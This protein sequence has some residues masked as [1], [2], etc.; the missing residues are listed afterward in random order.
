MISVTMNDVLNIEKV[1][2]KLV[3]QSLTGKKAFAMARLAREVEKEVATFENIRME[4]IRKYANKDE[5]GEA[6]IDD[7]GNVHL[8]EE[9]VKLC[10]Q[11]LRE[12]LEQEIELNVGPLHYDW[13]DDIELTMAE[14]DAFEPFMEKE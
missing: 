8:S 3:N 2:Q 7:N 5:N 1:F 12:S 9:N 14:A 13:F 4:L 10:N 11:E 6:I